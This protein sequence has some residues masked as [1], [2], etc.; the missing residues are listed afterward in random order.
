MARGLCGCEKLAL[1]L[2]SLRLLFGDTAPIFN[3]ASLVC[4]TAPVT[5]FKENVN[6]MY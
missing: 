3:A 1:S 2:V 4:L 5:V 6:H